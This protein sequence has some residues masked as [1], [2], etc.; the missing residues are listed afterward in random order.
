M[1]EMGKVFWCHSI[2]AI[3]VALVML[4]IPIFLLWIGYSFT[5]VLW[6]L[7][8]QQ[9][10]AALLQFPVAILFRFISPNR[11][12]V[13]GSMWYVV[14]FGML[15]TQQSHRWSLALLALVWALNRTIYWAAF[16]YNFGTARAHRGAGRQIAGINALIMVANT[17]APAV[18]GV[19]AEFCARHLRLAARQ[20][21][22]RF[23]SAEYRSERPMP[24]REGV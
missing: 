10:L 14:L 12:M 4:F 24:R 6:F 1:H 7:F 13:V 18:G 16:H 9:V 22:G 11:L 19:V 21:G 23:H 17:A 20:L 5:E 2:G 3:G 8:L 15:L